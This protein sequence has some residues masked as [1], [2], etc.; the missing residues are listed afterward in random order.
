MIYNNKYLFLTQYCAIS[1]AILRESPSLEVLLDKLDARISA[2][3]E[4][5]WAAAEAGTE[6]RPQVERTCD[7]CEK[8]RARLAHAR[9]QVKENVTNVE[10][11]R[12]KVKA[13]MIW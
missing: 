10:S 8:N 3:A 6:P 4:E 5:L 12:E 2:R 11:A 13:A 7:I 1:R 9:L